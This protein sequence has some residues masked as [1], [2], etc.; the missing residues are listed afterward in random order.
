MISLQGTVEEII[1]TN[2]ITGYTVCDIR[3]EKDI[4][5]AVGC[6]P[7]I[8]P[9]EELKLTGK[10]V[11]HPDYGDQLQV[12]YFEK[13]MPQT[14]EAIK[15]YL[16][17]GII[18]GI[19]P[20]TAE[21][22]VDRFGDET[23]EIFRLNPQKLS[24]IKGISLQRAIQMGQAFSE[25]E[26]IRNLVMFLQGFGIKS[27]ICMDIYKEL[28]ERA[29]EQIKENPYCLSERIP[30][31]S[32]KTADRIALQIGFDPSSSFRIY[33]GIKYI[34]HIAAANGHTYLYLEELSQRA[35]SL[36]AIGM[37]GIED[38]LSLLLFN[39]EIYIEKNED[40]DK[41]YLYIYYE[42]ELNIARKLAALVS[43]KNDKLIDDIKNKLDS[44]QKEEGL[45]LDHLQEK[46]IEGALCSGVF[47]ITGGPGTGKTTI[48]K[49][50]ISLL[51]QEGYK[52]ELAAPTGRAAKRL[53]EAT[54]REA[55]TI[56]RL[57]EI[58]Y[59]G[60]DR[61]MTFQKNE[62]NP[63][64]A[65]FV[66]IDE[67]SMVDTLLMSSLLS[68][69]PLGARLILVG[70]TDQ[71]PS[72]GAGNVLKDV[73]NSRLINTVRLTEIFRQAQESMI[74]VNAHRIIKGE[75]PFL[76]DREK[77]F[78][79]VSRRSPE[80]IIETIKDLC[81][82]RLP[83]SYQYD[84]LKHIQVLTPTR[85]GL[86]GVQNLNIEL[87]KVL[88]PPAKNKKEK[89]SRGYVFREGDR[90]MQ[91][92]NNYNLRWIK[93]GQNKFDKLAEGT[94][95]F[96][97]DTGVINKIDLEGQNLEVLFEDDRLAEYDFSI[98]DELEQ[99]FAITIHKSQGSEFPVI[100]IP[101]YPG[102]PVLLTRNLLYTAVTRARELVVLVGEEKVLHKM[103]KNCRESQRYTGLLD[104]LSL[105]EI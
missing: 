34:L 46:A 7:F 72:V 3:C 83:Q 28:G 33:S 13:L 30:Q 31:V 104:K 9:G 39:G 82:R 74:V 98:L 32:F 4:I 65:D 94:G 14:A 64:E 59:S 97:G 50:L 19:G 5:T 96:N 92:R 86:T 84:P 77:D 24:D 88:N 99:A 25:Q 62:E 42:A 55:R 66:I 20:V 79:F 43:Y 67:M 91:I 101:M 27:S 58:G 54:G 52:T 95:V 17:S 6:L 80:N 49:S 18:K 78:F 35:D 105:V 40:R 57:L 53:S 61:E 23:L 56:H 68:A 90:V 29:V 81:I 70:D 2:E 16:A 36:L 15:K 22:I 37:D 41:V 73:I 45:V 87:Q 26:G 51:E 8:N 10:W 48:I 75:K 93:R 21:K 103:V 12:E 60:N 102:P 63:I 85:K 1:Y 69:I 11:N 38:A 71:L 47:V 76:N 44:H 89:K 100:I